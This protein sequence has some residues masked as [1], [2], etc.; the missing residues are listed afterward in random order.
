MRRLTTGEPSTLGTYRNIALRLTKDENS[1][2]VK[3]FDELI[4]NSPDGENEFV[5][6]NETRMMIKISRM[7]YVK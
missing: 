7:I 1:D 2:V 3:Y 6:E 5:E 4:A